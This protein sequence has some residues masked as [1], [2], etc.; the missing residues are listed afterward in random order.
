MKSQFQGPGD[1]NIP[2]EDALTFEL[3]VDEGNFYL[4]F[5]NRHCSWVISAEQVR[6]QICLRQGF[7][8]R[9]SPGQNR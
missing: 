7:E 3:E 9:C 8:F 1:T 4:D 2:N 5:Y 6:S